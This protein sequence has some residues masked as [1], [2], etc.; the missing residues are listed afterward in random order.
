MPRTGSWHLDR[1]WITHAHY[2]PHRTPYSLAPALVSA[3]KLHAD[4]A[5]HSSLTDHD[6]ASRCPPSLQLASRLAA[7]T[8]RAFAAPSTT[9]SGGQQQQLKG[10]QEGQGQGGEQ[11]AMQ[12]LGSSVRA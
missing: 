6:C 7:R 11:V 3:G 12:Q 1:V 4:T 2:I 10:G 9:S 5:Q 8:I